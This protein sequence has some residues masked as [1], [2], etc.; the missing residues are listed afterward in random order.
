MAVRLSGGQEAEADDLLQEAAVRAV[1]G[2]QELRDPR[3]A[4]GWLFTILV[5]TFHN[6]RRAAR[7]RAETFVADLSEAEFEAA[8]AAWR[9][10]PTPEEVLAQ[11]DLGRRLTAALDTLDVSLRTVLWLV[12]GEGVRQREVAAM[13][14]LRE[15]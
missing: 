7:R 14:R 3:A 15:G 11:H 2:F 13:R 5:R 9:P 12:D 6:R 4:R 10:L 8:L 1:Q